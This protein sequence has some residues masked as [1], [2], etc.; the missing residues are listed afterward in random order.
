[1]ETRRGIYT[2]ADGLVRQ[3]TI[4]DASA[5]VELAAMAVSWNF[6]YYFCKMDLDL[7]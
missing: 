3:G 1:M 6:H 5:P 7:E 4:R 2:V